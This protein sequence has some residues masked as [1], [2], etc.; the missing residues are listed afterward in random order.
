MATLSQHYIT[1]R[2]KQIG[3][4]LQSSAR[5]RSSLYLE[6]FYLSCAFHKNW[7]AVL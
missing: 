2:S 1:L 6:G 5:K 7:H 4:H 3:L